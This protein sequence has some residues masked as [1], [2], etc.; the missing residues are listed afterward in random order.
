MPHNKPGLPVV[1]SARKELWE[2]ALSW[3]KTVVFAVVFALIVNTFI[4]VNASVPTGSM[5]D[6][7]QINDRLVALRLSYLFSDPERYDIVVFRAPDEPRKLYVKR[8]IG[9][10]GE[11]V[12]IKAGKVYIDDNQEPLEDFFVRSKPHEEDFGPV[13]VPDDSYFMLGDNRDNSADSRVWKNK[14]V[15]SK[16]I[17][18]KV[19]FRYFPNFKILYNL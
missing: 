12:T 8:V 17:L 6:T 15:V 10:P 13:T 9:L 1:P 19:L 2:E 3:A 5:L 16:D 11:T 14:F 18:G 7:I 4:I